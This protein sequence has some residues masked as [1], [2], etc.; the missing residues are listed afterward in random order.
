MLWYV[1]FRKGREKVAKW[2]YYHFLENKIKNE[3]VLVRE[4]KKGRKK[5]KKNQ[6]ILSPWKNMLKKKKI[7]RFKFGVWRVDSKCLHRTLRFNEHPPIVSQ[8][9]K[10]ENIF[11]KNHN[12]F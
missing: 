10:I 1:K 12:E 11:F 7:G 6:G 8:R 9:T 2:I 5:Y 3:L 4:K